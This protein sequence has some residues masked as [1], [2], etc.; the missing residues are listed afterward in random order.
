MPTN[1]PLGLLALARRRRD[2]I[3][4]AEKDQD[5][6]IF[7]HSHSLGD[8]KMGIGQKWRDSGVFSQSRSLESEN[9]RTHKDVAI[10]TVSQFSHVD[11][12]HENCTDQ[13]H[14][15]E[16]ITAGMNESRLPP[17]GTPERDKLDADH[18]AMCAGLMRCAD[19]AL[20]LGA[21]TS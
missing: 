19:V 15:A 7:S 5:S 2:L 21:P 4:A 16:E 11:K 17:L 1:A 6:E 20:W 18:K 9:M 14:E 8:E 10:L 13:D 3:A 12:N